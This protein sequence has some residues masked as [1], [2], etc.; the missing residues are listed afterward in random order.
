MKEREEKWEI[1]EEEEGK[2]G[3]TWGEIKRDWMKREG[4]K[5]GGKKDDK[6]EIGKTVA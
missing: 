2:G 6:G 3:R 1:V 5:R 4:R